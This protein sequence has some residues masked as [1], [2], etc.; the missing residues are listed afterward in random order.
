MNRM[1]P[2]LSELHAMNGGPT[3]YVCEN[4]ACRKPVVD[5]EGLRPYLGP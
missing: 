3:A 2:F 5:L 4:F 1:A